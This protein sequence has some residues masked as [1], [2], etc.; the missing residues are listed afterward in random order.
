MN[1]MLNEVSNYD[2][3]FVFIAL[4]YGFTITTRKK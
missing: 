3:A 4:V 1:R 2:F